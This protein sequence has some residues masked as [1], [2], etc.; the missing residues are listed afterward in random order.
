MGSTGKPEKI[1]ERKAA[2]HPR[3]PLP[4]SG[5]RGGKNDSRPI[6]PLSRLRGEGSGVRGGYFGWLKALERLNCS[7]IIGR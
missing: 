2:P 7:G 3:T 6:S 4:A 1:R 5:E